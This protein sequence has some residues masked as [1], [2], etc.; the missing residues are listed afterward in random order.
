MLQ[1]LEKYMP[2][3]TGISWSKPEGG[4]FLWVKLPEYMDTEQM[5]LEAAESKVIYVAGKPFHCDGTGRNTMRLKFLVSDRSPDC[6]RDT[7]AGQI[8]D[9]TCA[10]GAFDGASGGLMTGSRAFENSYSDRERAESYARLEFTGT[11]FLAY[12]DIPAIIETHASG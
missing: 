2:D 6:R 4:V 8:G 12:R 5:L 9:Q 1:S 10:A 3:I 7:A 11:Y